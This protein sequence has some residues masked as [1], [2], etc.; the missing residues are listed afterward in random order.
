MI[1][2]TSMGATH[3]KAYDLASIMHYDSQQGS[4][5]ECQKS[6]PK[7]CPLAL[8]VDKEKHKEQI[9]DEKSHYPDFKITDL[10]A[11]AI[12]ILYPWNK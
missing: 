11:E 9:I 5:P 1:E 4:R 10:D 8:W 2:D 12:K 3:S 7:E 6:K